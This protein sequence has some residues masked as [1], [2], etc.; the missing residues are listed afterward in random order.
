[1]TKCICFTHGLLHSIPQ[2]AEIEAKEIAWQEKK[3]SHNSLKLDLQTVIIRMINYKNLLLDNLILVIS[4][5]QLL[6]KV[7][8]FCE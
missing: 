4:L 5:L 7:W 8:S 6:F 2:S 1:M 3:N